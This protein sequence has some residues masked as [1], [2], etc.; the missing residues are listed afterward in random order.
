MRFRP[1]LSVTL[2]HGYFADGVA[3]GVAFRPDTATAKRLAGPWYAWQGRNGRLAVAADA[4]NPPPAD[5]AGLALRFLLWPADAALV[6]ASEAFLTA[7][8]Q[9]A[10]LSTEAKVQEADGRWRLHSGETVTADDMA[11]PAADAHAHPAVPERRPLADL[12]LTLPDPADAPLDCVV[13]FASRKV[14]WTYLVLGGDRLG[15]LSVVDAA[16]DQ[17]FERLEPVALPGQ[18]TALPFR[19]ANPLALAERTPYRFQLREQN[20]VADR[21][22]VRRLPA[23]SNRFRP[24]SG[25]DG[26]GMQAEIFVNL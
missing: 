18:R 22:L 19:S 24:I 10:R 20:S 1:L 16:G 13:R 6:P 11:E 14:F 7:G 8:P 25:P 21:V 5:E 17:A 2:E 15:P 9:M 4:A 23:A 26:P 12:S 3:Q